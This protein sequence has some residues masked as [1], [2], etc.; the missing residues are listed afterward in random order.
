MGCGISL[1]RE[2]I[3]MIIQREL[4]YDLKIKLDKKRLFDDYGNPIPETF[5]EEEHHIKITKILRNH[6]KKI[7]EEEKL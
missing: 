2:Q 6:L 3:I 1:S 7:Q 4:D 5:Y